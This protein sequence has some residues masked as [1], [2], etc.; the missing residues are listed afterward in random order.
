MDYIDPN[1]F[2][3]WNNRG[4]VTA[5]RVD[6]DLVDI[7]I[8]KRDENGDI[9]PETKRVSRA[10]VADI[11]QKSNREVNRLDDLL[12]FLDAVV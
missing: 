8:A 5:V 6:A 9:T 2:R 4:K 3:R 1:E 11:R 12:T 7:T 10:T